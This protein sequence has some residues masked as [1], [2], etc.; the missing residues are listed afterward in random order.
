MRHLLIFSILVIVSNCGCATA[1]PQTPQQLESWINFNLPHYPGFFDC[2]E[3]AEFAAKRLGIMGCQTH[4]VS[5]GVCGKGCFHDF[6][7][8]DCSNVG[9]GK[10]ELL[11]RPGKFYARSVT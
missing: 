4:A 5:T 6:V 11:N 1:V 3:K 9:M 7:V 2:T 8:Y 10:G